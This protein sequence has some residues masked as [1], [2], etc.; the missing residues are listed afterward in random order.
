MIRPEQKVIYPSFD[1]REENIKK[2]KAIAKTL[3]V[4]F[5][6][7]ADFE[8]FLVPVEDNKESDSNIKVRQQHKP[9]GFACIRVSQVPVVNGEIFT[10]SGE[11]CMTVF[12]EYIKDQDRNVHSILSDAKPTNPLTAEQQIAHARATTCAQCKEQF[13]KKNKK[14]K[15]YCH[16]IG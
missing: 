8:A 9:S 3:P 10:Y 15:H 2:Y 6:L 16:L 7:Y 11:D 1:N 5:V 13:T 14:T 4:P 12:F